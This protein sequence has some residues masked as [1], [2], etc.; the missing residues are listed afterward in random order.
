MTLQCTGVGLSENLK[1]LSQYHH[2][3][4]PCSKAT[5]KKA[6]SSLFV[7]CLFVGEKVAFLSAQKATM[8][9]ICLP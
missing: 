1:K 2:V 9:I 8:K 5:D 4:L 6:T 3:W 7:S